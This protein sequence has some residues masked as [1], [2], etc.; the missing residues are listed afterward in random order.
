MDGHQ[1]KKKMCPPATPLCPLDLAVFVYFSFYN[2]HLMAIKNYKKNNEIYEG[3][4][5]PLAKGK[6]KAAEKGEK[7]IAQVD[8]AKENICI[9]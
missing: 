4:L 6:R 5:S 2:L 3:S 9:F 1:K 8:L 7:N